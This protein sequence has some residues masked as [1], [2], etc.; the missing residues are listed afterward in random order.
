MRL[1]SRILILQE[2]FNYMSDFIKA[3]LGKFS[4]DCIL[5]F[6]FQRY[7]HMS[8]LPENMIKSSHETR[9]PENLKGK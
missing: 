8:I 5:R 3:F 9:S 1:Q 4:I 6:P 7:L 2:T